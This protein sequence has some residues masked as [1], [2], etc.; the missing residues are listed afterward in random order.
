[1]RDLYGSFEKSTMQ[2]GVTVYASTEGREP[3]NIRVA[4]RSG[5]IHDPE[6]KEGTAHFLEHALTVAAN[7]MEEIED[8]FAEFGGTIDLG[9]TSD[10]DMQFA[11]FTP[12]TKQFV[13]KALDVLGSFVLHDPIPKDI[14]N[15]RE[16]ILSEFSD[17]Y[18][19]CAYYRRL[20]Q[21]NKLL[22]HDDPWGRFVDVFGSKESIRQITHEDLETYRERFFVGRNVTIIGLGSMHLQTLTELIQESPFG[23]LRA[24]EPVRRL[25][26]RSELSPPQGTEMVFPKTASSEDESGSDY[27]TIG[28]IPGTVTKTAIELAHCLL[29]RS[30]FAELRSRTGG[31]YDTKP[32]FDARGDCY[33][34]ELK[35]EQLGT[36][37]FKRVGDIINTC[38]DGILNS[39][40]DLER[41]R[42]HAIARAPMINESDHEICALVADHLISS[43]RLF[44]L[45]EL[46]EMYRAVTLDDLRVIADYL[47]PEMRW[48]LLSPIK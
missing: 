8:T 12:P 37:A 27:Y 47:K 45:P 9:E 34:F 28:R 17:E 33:N 40:E 48:T 46:E 11:C 38:I 29:N 20:L 1:M 35:L 13:A 39:E 15:E 31:A 5:A 2:N 41:E 25:E 42:Q 14:D 26:P 32:E 6:G 4:I 30:L 19:S 43:E 10:S 36:R 21:G 16:N 18:H 44:S 22:H 3:E 24:G 7:R 23:Q